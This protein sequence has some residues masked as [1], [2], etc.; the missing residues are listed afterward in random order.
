[1]DVGFGGPGLGGRLKV[2]GGLVGVV[3]D[4]RGRPLRLLEPDED[5]VARLQ[6]W[7][8]TVGGDHS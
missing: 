6:G 4:A 3:I 5:R 2:T 1:V 7:M 8:R